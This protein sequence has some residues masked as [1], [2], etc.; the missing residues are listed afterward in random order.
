[1]YP[2]EL[3]LTHENVYLKKNNKINKKL[4][5]EINK[6]IFILICYVLSE[7]MQKKPD[8]IFFVFVIF[9]LLF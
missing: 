2:S 5:K 3:S 1:M 9:F 6:T 8:S 7:L 4:S